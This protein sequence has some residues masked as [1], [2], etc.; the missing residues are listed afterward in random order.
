MALVLTIDVPLILECHSLSVSWY[1]AQPSNQIYSSFQ[2]WQITSALLS[3]DHLSGFLLLFCPRVYLCFQCYLCHISVLSFFVQCNHLSVCMKLSNSFL[4]C[5]LQLHVNL[6]CYSLHICLV[7][8]GDFTNIW[9]AFFATIQ[10]MDN[11]CRAG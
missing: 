2:I 8:R 4:F 3:V 1:Q 10:L 6:F 7:K 5:F 9:V 11:Y